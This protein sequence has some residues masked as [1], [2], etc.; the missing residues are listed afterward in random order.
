MSGGLSKS[1]IIKGL[2]CPKALWLAKNPPD[3]DFPPRPD[4]QTKFQFGTD[5]GILA[6]QLFPGGIEVPFEGLSFP[7]QLAWTKEL[8][9]NCVSVVHITAAHVFVP[10]E[11]P[12]RCVRE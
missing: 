1:L 5:V 3:F 11:L 4:L 8:I 2:Q 9:D 10:S 7:A 12:A 6:Q